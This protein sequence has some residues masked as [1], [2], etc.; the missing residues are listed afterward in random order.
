MGAEDH[1]PAEDDVHARKLPGGGADEGVGQVELGV[2]GVVVDGLLRAGE[3]DGL[4]GALH[5][6]AQCRGGIGHGVGA[7]ADDEAVIV[8]VMLADG[9]GGLQPVRGRDVGGIK[10]EQVQAVHPADVPDRGHTA[11]KLRRR[12]LRCQT[13]GRHLRGDGSAGADHEDVFHIRALSE[14]KLGLFSL[15]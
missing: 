9:P 2:G 12:K 13:L 4:V 8:R 6:I 14:D 5:Q 7:V 15:L 11:Q 3:H 1:A 10:A